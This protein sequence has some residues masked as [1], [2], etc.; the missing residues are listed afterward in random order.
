MSTKYSLKLSTSNNDSLQNILLLNLLQTKFISSLLILRNIFSWL[1]AIRK[2]LKLIKKQIDFSWKFF[3]LLSMKIHHYFLW[4][5]SD[6]FFIIF[7]WL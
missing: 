6:N 7:N 1:L 5:F 4:C 3:S 2:L